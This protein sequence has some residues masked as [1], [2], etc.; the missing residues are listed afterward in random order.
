MLLAMIIFSELYR[1]L[2]IKKKRRGRD[3]LAGFLRFS[4]TLGGILGSP[5]GARFPVNGRELVRRG[6]LREWGRC[7]LFFFCPWLPR[8]LP[9]CLLHLLGLLFIPL[10]CFVFLLYLGIP[11]VFSLALVLLLSHV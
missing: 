6:K 9:R 8:Q 10:L 5:G 11:L 7:I 1:M 3:V 4:L 2:V